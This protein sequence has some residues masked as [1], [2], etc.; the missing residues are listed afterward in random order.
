MIEIKLLNKSANE[1]IDLAAA[2]RNTGLQQGTDFEFAFF[3]SK[4]N[5][6]IGEIPKYV[7]F[8]FYKKKDATM[9]ALRW[10]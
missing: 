3:Q 4:W 1:A 8:K 7:V 5:N 9:F 2:L 6:V 10:A